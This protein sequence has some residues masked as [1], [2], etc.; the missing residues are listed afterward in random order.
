[1]SVRNETSSRYHVAKPPLGANERLWAAAAASTQSCG[2]GESSSGELLLLDAGSDE[3]PRSMIVEIVGQ[4]QGLDA[5][6]ADCGV[7]VVE[8]QPTGGKSF[9][10][11]F[12]IDWCELVLRIRL[13]DI[14][15]RGALLG[16]TR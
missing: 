11:A 3:E 16:G 2:G 7:L 5:F 6:V 13:S 1:M 15:P 12:S 14:L 9:G 4:S 10:A 8:N